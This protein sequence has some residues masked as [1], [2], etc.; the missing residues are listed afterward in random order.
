MKKLFRPLCSYW[1]PG[2]LLNQ[3]NLFF[4]YSTDSSPNSH[5]ALVPIVAA[6]GGA[7]EMIVAGDSVDT[8]FEEGKLDQNHELI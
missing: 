7:K 6:D 3:I 2:V 8:T 5:L 4:D 1:K